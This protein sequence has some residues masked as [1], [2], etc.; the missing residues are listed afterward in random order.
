MAAAMNFLPHSDVDMHRPASLDE[1]CKQERTVGQ[2]IPR[3]LSRP[4]LSPE[5]HNNKLRRNNRVSRLYL[6][7]KR[8]AE[9][10]TTSS[11]RE[12]DGRGG[13]DS[14]VVLSGDGPRGSLLIEETKE[15]ARV[16]N[17]V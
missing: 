15:Q 16:S 3:L 4:P 10:T 1:A 8:S 13:D 12:S 2:L 9:I 5:V 6:W 14:R 7:D 11:P 17:S